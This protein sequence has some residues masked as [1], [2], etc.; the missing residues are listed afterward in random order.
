MIRGVSGMEEKGI[1]WG[2]GLDIWEIEGD[3]IH[4]RSQVPRKPSCRYSPYGDC[5]GER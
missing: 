1:P 2:A 3:H 5:M 4:P